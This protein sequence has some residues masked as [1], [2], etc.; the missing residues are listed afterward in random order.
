MMESPGPFDAVIFDFGGVFTPSPV[1]MFEEYERLHGLPDRYIGT[2][3]KHNHL[4]NSWAR[5]ERAEIGIEAFD[6]L[7]AEESAKFGHTIPGREIVGLLSFTLRPE[8]I[9]A[10]DRM[11]ERGLKTG[12][13]TNN[14]PELDWASMVIDPGAVSVADVFARFDAVIESSQAGVRKPDPAIYR[15]MCERLNV[16]PE[17][18]IF[19][20]DLGI[21]LKPAQALGMTTIKV[22]F[23]NAAPAIAELDRLTG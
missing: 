16:Q 22:P 7:F 4:E 20:D 8:M 12:C 3:I 5:Y 11:R 23:G 19:L 21:N 2:V 17:R 15:M 14:M 6:T 1:E 18:C 13:I 9:A 10:L